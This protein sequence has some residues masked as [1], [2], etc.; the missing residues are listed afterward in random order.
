VLAIV[1]GVEVDEFYERTEGDE[2]DEES[3]LALLAA[4]LEAHGQLEMA[5]ELRARAQRIAASRRRLRE[6]QQL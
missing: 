1:L 4:E 5:D 6:R 3:D 2:D